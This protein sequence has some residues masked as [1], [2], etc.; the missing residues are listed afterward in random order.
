MNGFGGGNAADAEVLAAIRG[1]ATGNIGPYD[2]S[3]G[4]PNGP[5]D[6]RAALVNG[7]GGNGPT[8]APMRIPQGLMPQMQPSPSP[9]QAMRGGMPG[10]LDP[11]ILAMIQALQGNGGMS[12]GGMR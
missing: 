8:G 12:G 2:M 9:Q 3:Q 4:L 7:I 1:G 10:Q 5:L 11:R 6:P